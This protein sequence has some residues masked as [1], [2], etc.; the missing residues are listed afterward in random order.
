MTMHQT[1]KAQPIPAH[2]YVHVPFCS[3]KCSYC[4]FFSVRTSPAAVARY[5]AA[6]AVEMELRTDSRRAAQIETIYCGGGTPSILSAAD[7]RTLVAIL[8]RRFDLSALR[9]WTVEANPGTLSPAKLRLLRDAGVTRI[10][11]GVQAWDDRTLRLLG[12]RHSVADVPRTVDAIRAAGIPDIGIDLIAALPG[13]PEAAWER[14]LQCMLA[15]RPGHVSVYALSLERGTRL[16]RAA[17]AG[18]LD[19]P[20]EGKQVRALRL[21][22]AALEDAGLERYE[23]SNFARPGHECLHNLAFW[24][25]GDYIGFGPAAASRHGLRRWTNRADL[26]AYC[27]ALSQ[28][29]LPPRRTER[30]SPD[31]DYA[32]RLAFAFRLSKGI[33]PQE[34]AERVPLSSQRPPDTWMT[35]LDALRRARLLR[36]HGAI[37]F[38]TERGRD[39]ADSI[40]SSILTAHHQ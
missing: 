23:I 11:L 24:R 26:R 32:E 21:A 29:R 25:G 35:T 9:E 33:D 2:V 40:A 17:L 3:G 6:L 20:G 36:R 18:R 1:A 4:A 30:L 7:W 10:S 5:L 14:T 8:R 12:R 13:V 15:L 16:R 22:A 27:A 39:L 31:R 37:W 34:L 38:A 28:G 19:V